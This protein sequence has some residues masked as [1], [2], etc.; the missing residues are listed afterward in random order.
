MGK[1]LPARGYQLTFYYFGNNSTDGA[2]FRI[3]NSDAG[4]HI[5]FHATKE[6]RLTRDFHLTLDRLTHLFESGGLPNC[7][8]IHVE[9][10]CMPE[11]FVP[12]IAT[13]VLSGIPMIID[14]VDYWHPLPPRYRLTKW[15]VTQFANHVTLCSSELA[16]VES[17]SGKP[18]TV[19]PMGANT[20]TVTAF[21]TEE[22]KSC[23]NL[24]VDMPIIGFEF[25]SG[26]RR[27]YVDFLL[28]AFLRLRK[29]MPVKLAF[30][31][32]I[33]LHWQRWYLP[34]LMRRVREAGIEED[35]VV[36]GRLAEDQLSL[37]LSS[38]DVLLMPLVDDVI[39]RTRFPGRFGDYMAASR[40]VVVSDVG[41]IGRY[42]K[43]WGCGSAVKWAD[44]EGYSDAIFQ[45]L[46]DRTRKE[47][48]HYMMGRLAQH[49]SWES[50][51]L[52]LADLYDSLV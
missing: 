24:P 20:D 5:V 2:K 47:E 16:K 19:I 21:S 23:L 45:L 44:V 37:W 33:E 50:L 30:I 31:G 7:D 52:K 42:V 17:W 10:G 28:S 22:A 1:F 6:Y 14:W 40:P 9:G 15:V 29:R 39:D 13:K 27:E 12:S 41:D 49:Q 32:Y 18:A 43:R 3:I 25:G 48:A 38:C 34:Y 35:V 46:S 36:T 4:K 11:V 26:N 51:A 8:L